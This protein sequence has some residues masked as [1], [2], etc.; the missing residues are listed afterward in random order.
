MLL[1]L[2]LLIYFCVVLVGVD[3][4]LRLWY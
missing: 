2:L 1:G 3:R 4:W